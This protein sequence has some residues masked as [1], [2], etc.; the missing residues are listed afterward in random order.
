M[1]TIHLE[2]S[3]NKNN[4]NKMDTILPTTF[5]RGAA[6]PRDR[7]APR[8]A[9]LDTYAKRR[10][11]I[12]AEVEA[13]QAQALVQTASVP[14]VTQ[15][16]QAA[17]TQSVQPAPKP[18]VIAVPIDRQ[19]DFIQEQPSSES[20]RYQ[21]LI[22]EVKQPERKNYLDTLTQRHQNAVAAAPQ[23]EDT[24]LETSLDSSLSDLFEEPEEMTKE[25]DD[26]LEANLQALYKGSLTEQIAKNTSSASASHVRTIVAS[27]LACGIMAVGIFSFFGKYDYVP[28]VA[29][30]IGS[31]VIEVESSNVVQRPQGTSG[32]A[33]ASAMAVDVL[34][35][36]KL[37]ISSIGV[38]TSVESLGQTPSGLIEVPKS[39]GVAGWYNKSSV[40]GKS[41]PA[42]LVGHYTGG[43]N[44][45]FDN[46]KNL[47]N[48][49]LITTTNSKGQSITYKVTAMNEYDRDK[50]PM[51][52]IFK[53]SKESRLEIITCAGKW[54]ANTYNKRLVVTAQL[55]K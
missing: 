13:A 18:T 31:P 50:V 12:T 10:A 37:T 16:L 32:A 6:S 46:L 27:A 40:P 55:V 4:K 33:A 43:N 15:S 11:G 48:G 34:S 39:Y 2:P 25:R 14:V 29:Q 7:S 24:V 5:S 26:K 1:S 52:E 9:Y 51:A 36:V 23:A 38:N 28:V 45:V 47:K 30:P 3:S 22:S 42:V 53:T 19:E 17:P 49:D 44:G 41:G 8:R 54:Q 35:P 20:F 21:N